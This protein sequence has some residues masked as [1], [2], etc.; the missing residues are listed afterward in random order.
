MTAV[1]ATPDSLDLVRP[2]AARTAEAGRAVDAPGG[3]PMC[4]MHER[5]PGWPTMATSKWDSAGDHNRSGV[6]PFITRGAPTDR[7]VVRNAE[8]VALSQKRNSQ[9][10]VHWLQQTA[11]K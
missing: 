10:K 6:G 5:E 4:P 2:R 9:R 3:Q 8:E 11:S 1:C 7:Q